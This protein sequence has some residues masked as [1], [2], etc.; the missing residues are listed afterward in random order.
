MSLRPGLMCSAGVSLRPVLWRKGVGNSGPPSFAVV[1]RG[2]E[3]VP[4]PCVVV[5][6]GGEHSPSALCCGA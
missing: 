3:P 6:R 1:Q 2:C 5:H 4:P